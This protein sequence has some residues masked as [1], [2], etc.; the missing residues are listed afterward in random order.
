MDIA[1]INGENIDMLN[2]TIVKNCNEESVT[3][4]MN[5]TDSSLYFQPSRMKCKEV[6]PSSYIFFKLERN[7]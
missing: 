3:T 5:Q 1:L 2:K 4:H 6:I 7:L